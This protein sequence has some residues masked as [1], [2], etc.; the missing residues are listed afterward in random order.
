MKE[1][2]NKPDC[3]YL[4][5]INNTV[6]FMS[7]IVEKC[8]NEIMFL[9]NSLDK[10]KFSINKARRTRLWSFEKAF[11]GLMKKHL[12]LSQTQWRGLKIG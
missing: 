1:N 4:I 7:K 8:L 10:P 5:T 3:H 2:P 12:L 6:N 11:R 9:R